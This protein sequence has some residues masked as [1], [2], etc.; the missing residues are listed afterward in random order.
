VCHPSTGC[1]EAPTLRV[2]TLLL[3][4]ALFSALLQGLSLALSRAL[5]SAARAQAKGLR[6]EWHLHVPDRPL[7]GDATRLRQAPAQLRHQC[8]QVHG[9]RWHRSGGPGGKRHPQ[10]PVHPFPGRD[11]GIGVAPDVLPRLFSAFEQADNSTTRRNGGTG[12][13]LAKTEASADA[14]TDSI[15]ARP[16][17]GLQREHAGRLVLVV[18]DE[19]VNQEVATVLL[20]DVGLCVAL[21]ADGQEAVEKVAANTYDLVL[22]DMQMPRMDGLE[23]ARRIRQLPNGVNLPI[24]TMTANAFK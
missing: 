17:L 21:A 9:R 19:P 4:F 12:L 10:P 6:L 18:E 24:I 20:E 22:M 3:A 11:T 23:A 7:L 15:L 16:E 2:A 1:D 13:G 5:K 14:T 8:R